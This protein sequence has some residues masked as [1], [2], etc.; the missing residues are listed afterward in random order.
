MDPRVSILDRRLCEVG[1]IIAVTGGKGGVGKS[2]ITAALGLNLSRL[3]F[4]VA[5]LDL[6]LTSPSLHIILGADDIFPEEEKG[7]IPPEVAGVKLM[8][9]I[10]FTAR[11]PSP[12]RGPDIS[13]ATLELL[14]NTIWGEIDFLMVDM[15]PGVG[16][17]MMDIIRWMRGSEFLIVSNPSKL[18]LETVIKVIRLLTELDLPILGVIE[19]MKRGERSSWEKLSGFGIPFL[20][21]LPYF[22][23]L[24]DAV[25]N[26]EM[27]L[28]SGFGRRLGEIAAGLI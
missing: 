13:N 7:I 28:S 23:D 11:N 12:L 8:S 15:P 16:D 20:G 10:Y 17:V 25:G 5:L 6:D 9:I 22:E 2:L 1:R 26:P 27:L 18:V 14:A 24:E 4:R 19:N 3:G 21:E